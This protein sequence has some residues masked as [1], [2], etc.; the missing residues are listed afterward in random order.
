MIKALYARTFS[1]KEQQNTFW[2]SL[3][4][5]IPTKQVEIKCFHSWLLS[6]PYHKESIE[7]KSC[8]HVE[9]ISQQTFNYPTQRYARVS[10][11]GDDR[12]SRSS[13]NLFKCLFFLRTWS[14]PTFD[15][16]CMCVSKGSISK[17]YDSHP[18]RVKNI[19]QAR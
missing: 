15:Q 5:S 19:P 3:L 17:Q 8:W 9:C 4:I 16:I 18:N 2:G 14:H 10:L 7:G 13:Y 1:E 6:R 11:F 12:I